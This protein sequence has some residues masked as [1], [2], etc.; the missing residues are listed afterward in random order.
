MGVGG[1]WEIWAEYSIC[2]RAD[3]S[4]SG[5]VDSCGEHKVLDWVEFR[6]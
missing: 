5:M 4:L 2:L 1:N 3:S 6:Q